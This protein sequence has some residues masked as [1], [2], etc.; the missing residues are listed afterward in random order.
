MGELD[1]FEKNMLENDELLVSELKKAL[2]ENLNEDKNVSED[3]NEEIK[4]EKKSKKKDKKE[5][6]D[7]VALEKKKKINERIT[8][9]NETKKFNILPDIEISK[10]ELDVL[11]A[12][13]N[14]E[15]VNDY[16]TLCK[17]TDL[18]PSKLDKCL[19]KLV[20]KNMLIIKD[21]NI[22]TTELGISFSKKTKSQDN[23]NRKFQKFIKI[24]TDEE[25]EHFVEAVKSLKSDIK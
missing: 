20:N 5:K 15:K 16:M 8:I 2:A 4:E 19:N 1:M 18:K 14:E 7:K 22:T 3:V 23:R 12:L 24:L 10:D 21:G 9:L 6:N 17:Y 25:F 11:K 13:V